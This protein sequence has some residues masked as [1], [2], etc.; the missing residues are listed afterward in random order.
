MST[1]EASNAFE[2]MR[3]QQEERRL[4]MI[5]EHPTEHPHFLTFKLDGSVVPVITCPGPDLCQYQYGT[6]AAATGDS[7]CGLQLEVDEIGSEFFDYQVG[8]P[9]E[10]QG[11]P[12]PIHFTMTFMED[13]PP[14]VEW[15]IL[16]APERDDSIRT[17]V[18]IAGALRESGLVAGEG[19]I[20]QIASVAAQAVLRATV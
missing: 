14:E 17:A 12:I 11:V 19:Y 2:R 10:V 7:K 9:F 5:A 16:E 4:D 8:P 6:K 1:P 3:R 13:D 20:L 18:T 15:W